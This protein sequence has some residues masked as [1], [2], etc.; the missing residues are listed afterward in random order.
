MAILVPIEE[1]G[2]KEDR[3]CTS[4][5]ACINKECVNPCEAIAPCV[6]NADCVVHN[7]LPLRTMTCIC[8]EGYTGRGD[9][10]CTEIRKLRSIKFYKDIRL[11]MI[12]F[13]LYGILYPFNLFPKT[14][15]IVAEC[16]RDSDCTSQQ[17][18]RNERCVN[19]CSI[20][21]PCGELAI[22]T[23]SSH[24]AKCT[25]QAGFEGDPYS[26]CR[27]SKFKLELKCKI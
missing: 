7:T 13:I 22:C 19:P 14:A 11:G 5:Q 16:T 2:C 4:K 23:V 9:Q 1:P 24:K 8:I 20:D 17:A 25:C 18:C 3:E 12:M 27:K 26:R 21:A 6:Q 10:F 15:E